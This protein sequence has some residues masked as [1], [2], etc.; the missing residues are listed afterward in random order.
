MQEK[1]FMDFSAQKIWKIFLCSMRLSC[2][3]REGC[4][5]FWFKWLAMWRFIWL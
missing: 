3:R 1:S 4:F 2:Y 5:C